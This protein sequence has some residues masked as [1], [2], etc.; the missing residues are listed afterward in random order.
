MCKFADHFDNEKLLGF[1]SSAFVSNEN[2]F[3]FSFP[4]LMF[5]MK[6][7]S[8]F[9]FLSIC[10]MGLDAQSQTTFNLIGS[11][12]GANEKMIFFSYRGLGN[13][14]IWDSTIVHNNTFHFSGNIP[15][16]AKALLTDRATDRL[17]SI[18]EHVS[19]P[20][21]IEPGNDKII[22]NVNNFRAAKITG[23][24]TQEDFELLT[25]MKSRLNTARIPL[26]KL[27]DLLDE[28]FTK[29]SSEMIDPGDTFM[30][31]DPTTD[32]IPGKEKEHLPKTTDHALS[33]KE[34]ERLPKGTD[35]TLSE[36]K[37]EHLFKTK[38]HALSEKKREHLFKTN[39]HAL[40]QLIKKINILNDKLQ[41][42]HQQELTI[43]RKFFR[44]HPNSYI[45]AYEIVEMN[46][47][48]GLKELKYYHNKMPL[49]LQNTSYGKEIS[50]E[51]EKLSKGTPGTMASDFI[52]TQVDGDTIRL[53]DY[54]GKF[55]LLDFWA[56]WCKPC[57]AGN[58]EL[59]K[60]YLKYHFNGIEF[61]G[62][63][64]DNKLENKW[65]DA[66][67]KDGIG[68]WNQVLMEDIGSLYH[69]QG[70]PT[71][72]LI[73]PDGKIIGRYNIDDGD[74]EE[75][76]PIKLKSLFGQ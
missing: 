1:F 12:K 4:Q 57:R 61:I 49:V 14:R 68:I 27:R 10:F 76:L 23:S 11:I 24:K 58:P 50:S 53:S 60:L 40:S 59:K 35:H 33:E 8:V 7:Y 3:C 54:K 55:V 65:Q 18:D 42:L 69:I 34:R 51:I 25:T 21:F 64:N 47:H 72:I 63:A 52:A 44:G 67:V 5:Q 17:S 2:L 56:S 75:K 9:L 48:F 19:N 22:L 32:P 30:S 15:E 16:P 38:D 26:V 20:F 6:I 73:D 39:D 13:D 70:L 74:Q 29:L 71:K 62:L 36:K 28:Q 66:I 46:R 41:I 43:D 37:R 31:K 45:T